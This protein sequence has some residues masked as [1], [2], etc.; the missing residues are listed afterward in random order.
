[1]FAKW[2][3]ALAT[4]LAAVQMLSGNAL[5]RQVTAGMT[6]KWPAGWCLLPSK[7]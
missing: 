2:Q 7:A 3:W 6:G 5:I 4:H 1:M